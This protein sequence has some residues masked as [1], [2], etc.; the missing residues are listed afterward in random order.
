MN[1]NAGIGRP[2]PARH[3]RNA[4]S[5]GQRTV[6]TGHEGYPALLTAYHRLNLRHI[7][8]RIKHRKEALPRHS[9]NTVT[10]LKD[11]LIDQDAAAGT[12][13]CHHAAIARSLALRQATCRRWRTNP[14]APRLISLVA[15]RFGPQ[16]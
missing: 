6:R 5:L 16:P 11:K 14:H 1:A 10:S 2:R 3:K 12:W 7:M 13:I 15:L 8:E 4:G 9:E